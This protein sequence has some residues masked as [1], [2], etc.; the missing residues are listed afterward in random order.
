[1]FFWVE[2][3]FEISYERL[4]YD[5]NH[6]SNKLDNL[7]GYN[8]TVMF[9]KGLLNE[10]DITLNSLTETL[11]NK[12]EKIF[13]NINT[14]GTTSEPK[15]VK[16]KLSNCI[17]HV[18]FNS[19]D[20]KKHI[21]AMGYPVGSYASTQVLFQCLFNLETIIYIYGSNFSS[22]ENTFE[23]YS[24]TNLSCTPTF[25]SMMLMQFS[26]SNSTLK[27]ITTGGEKINSNLIKLISRVFTR[28]EYINIYASSETGSLLRSKSDFFSIPKRYEH[29]IKIIDNILHSIIKNK[30]EWYSTN[31]EVEMLNTKEFKFVSRSNGYL[32]T[33]GYRINPSEIE[34]QILKIKGIINVHV[35]GKPNTLLGTVMCADIIGDEIEVKKLKH[36]LSKLMPKHKIPRLFRKVD[37]FE[38]VVNGKKKI[39]I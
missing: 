4:I 28:A 26:K 5:I 7:P 16:V 23:I 22:L 37:V 38:H 34:E 1:M 8:S 32:N 21:W 33:G 39:M 17:R 31:D 29:R 10:K 13:F 19:K 30:S 14:S 27:K 35:Y 11:Q 25:L 12:K 9:L 6:N 36:E 24:P 18:K 2:N 3:G 20:R 15:L